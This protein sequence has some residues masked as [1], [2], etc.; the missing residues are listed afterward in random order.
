MTL[1]NYFVTEIDLKLAS[2]LQKDLAEQ[3][4][5]FSSVPHA[6]LAA[7][8]P[9]ISCTLYK[10]GKLVIQ[11]KKLQ[12]FIEF[13]LEPDLL[14]RFG[15]LHKIVPTTTNTYQNIIGADESGKGDFFGPLCVAAVHASADQLA[16][17]SSIGVQDSKKISDLKI[18]VLAAKIKQKLSFETLVLLPPKYNELYAKFLNLNTMLAWCHVTLIKKITARTGC[19]EVILDQFAKEYVVL[20]ELKR[21]KVEVS[22]TQKPRAEEEIIVAAASILARNAF[23][24]N[25]KQLAK[26]IGILLPKG[27]GAATLSAGHEILLKFGKEALQN[28]CKSHFKNLD[29]ILKKA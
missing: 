18:P 24:E 4:F 23:L 27:G 15:L 13:Y 29:S 2:K 6:L 17:L 20:S 10:S 26:S 11:G 7:K 1:D 22:I 12:E 8:K 9:G 14:G 5:T 25:L 19:N 16:Y 28:V 3:S 21:R